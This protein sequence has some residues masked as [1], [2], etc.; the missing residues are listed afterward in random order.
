[1]PSESRIRL[2]PI[3]TFISPVK[4]QSE[5]CRVYWDLRDPPSAAAI[6]VQD[7]VSV[8]SSRTRHFHRC[9]LAYQ[10]ISS[11]DATNPPV[12][13]FQI[14]CDLLPFRW[15]IEARND[16]GVKVRDVIEAIYKV[17]QIPLRPDEWERMSSKDK[18]RIQAAYK[19]RWMNAVHPET[20]RLQGVRRIDC[21][22]RYTRFGGLSSSFDRSYR[23]VLTLSRQLPHLGTG[24]NAS[25]E[26]PPS[27]DCLQEPSRQ[28]N[29]LKK[30][31]KKET[32]SAIGESKGPL[33]FSTIF[34]T[35]SHGTRTN[36]LNRFSTPTPAHVE[37]LGRGRGPQGNFTSYVPTV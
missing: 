37:N 31:R 7:P 22:L 8:A 29:R 26:C 18:D 17:A 33:R 27:S 6:P 14:I 28:T 20:E 1:M 2:N 12:S 32:A 5:S 35:A 11:D 3:L 30:S 25:N 16:R 10:L 21:L 36:N 24:G 34:P 15:P 4:P 9:H 23:C 13:R 19:L